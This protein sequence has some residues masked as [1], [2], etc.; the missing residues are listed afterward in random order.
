MGAADAGV[1]T[2]LGAV[3][4]VIS[5]IGLAFIPNLH[6]LI[7]SAIPAPGLFLLGLGA[8]GVVLFLALH[9]MFGAIVGSYYAVGLAAPELPI[10][11]GRLHTRP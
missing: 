7:P 8:W 6:P 5:G 3:H 9:L 11:R 2:T 4:A 10:R 1:G